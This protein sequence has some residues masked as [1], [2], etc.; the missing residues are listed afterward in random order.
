M[1]AERKGRFSQFRQASAPPAAPAAAREETAT[2]PPRAQ[3]RP[4]RTAEPTRREERAQ[5]AVEPVDAPQATGTPYLL[6]R[7]SK[8]EALARLGNGVRAVTKYAL[9]DYVQRLKRQGW[10]V[11][12]ARVM[13]GMFI[14]LEQDPEFQDALTRFL[15]GTDDS[16]S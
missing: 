16:T 5:R 12:E 13:E 14:L 11:T 8:G 2:E 1:A 3:E 10:P 9:E 4:E 15:T 6:Q 7:F